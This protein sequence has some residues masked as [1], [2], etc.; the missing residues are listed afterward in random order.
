[1]RACYQIPDD[2]FDRL[3]TAFG[4]RWVKKYV[5][6]EYV[7]NGI[8]HVFLHGASN[9]RCY[10]PRRASLPVEVTR[11]PLRDAWEWT[12]AKKGR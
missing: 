3:I 12:R 8:E 5:D 10:V 2:E 6:S 1:M 7:T 11:Q 9:G 4:P